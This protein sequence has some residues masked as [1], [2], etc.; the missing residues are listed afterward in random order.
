MSKPTKEECFAAVEHARQLCRAYIASQDLRDAE[1]APPEIYWASWPCVISEAWPCAI[2]VW[3]RN[4]FPSGPCEAAFVCMRY[5]DTDTLLRLVGGGLLPQSLSY[6]A[7]QLGAAEAGA[8]V[9]RDVA[10]PVLLKLLSHE[11]TAVREGALHGLSRGMLRGSTHVMKTKR[12]A[13]ERVA[14]HDESEYVRKVAADL[15]SA[16]A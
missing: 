15:L 6:A 11:S 16:Q 8:T 12:A 5:Y 1:F 14:L 13:V 7:E 10:L 9:L 4:A 2:P 3:L